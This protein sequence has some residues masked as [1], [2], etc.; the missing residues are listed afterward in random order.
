M[1]LERSSIHFN[2][3]WDPLPLF[4]FLFVKFL[5]FLNWQSQ[6]SSPSS[7]LRLR[8][9]LDA[10]LSR[11]HAWRLLDA[12]NGRRGNACEDEPRRES[13]VTPRQRRYVGCTLPTPH[14]VK[15][16]MKLICPLSPTPLPACARSLS[17]SWVRRK[18]AGDCQHDERRA[19]STAEPQRRS[20]RLSRQRR[21]HGLAERDDG[22]R[23]MGR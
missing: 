9:P 4:N 10:L 1:S 18:H 16:S 20:A 23:D 14:T 13:H 21:Q 12:S 8:W 17:L 11:H 2:L 19:D 6:C 3:G 22:W 5:E 7:I 15:L